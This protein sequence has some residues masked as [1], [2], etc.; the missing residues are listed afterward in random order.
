MRNGHDLANCFLEITEITSKER[1]EVHVVFDRYHIQNSLKQGTRQFRQGCNRPMVYQI[2]DGAV[3]K[4]ITFKQLLSSNFDKGSLAMYS[5][6]T[7]GVTL[8]SECRSN[9]LRVHHLSITQE[10]ADTR[11]LLH[12]IDATE[13][14]PTSLYIQSP[15]T[16]VLI[17]ALWK[18]TS[19]CKEPSVVAGTR[20]KRRSIPLGP[21]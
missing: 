10:E 18:Y 5:Q 14:R 16:D 21:L 15:G 1:D 7:C 11:M 2:S 9:N 8:K 3:I 17:L 20:A 13:R 6:K 12:A 19:L 4:K